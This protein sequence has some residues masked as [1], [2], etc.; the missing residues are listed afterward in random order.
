[1]VQDQQIPHK[2]VFIFCLFIAFSAFSFL[3]FSFPFL[4]CLLR[5]LILGFVV[6]C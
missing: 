4:C 5:T 3:S 6:F 2:I 1:M